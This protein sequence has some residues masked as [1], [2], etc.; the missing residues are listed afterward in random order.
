MKLRLGLSTK[1]ATGV[2]ITWAVFVYYDGRIVEFDRAPFLVFLTLGTLILGWG[3]RK[4]K[5]ALNPIS[6]YSVF[7]YSLAFQFLQVSYLQH[8]LGW[9]TILILSLAII[10]FLVP[11]LMRSKAKPLVNLVSRECN[12]GVYR[13][14]FYSAVVT[15]IIEAFYNQSLP[16]LNEIQGRS[17][18]GYFVY[19]PFAHYFVLMAAVLPAIAVY[20]YKA[21]QIGLG[22]SIWQGGISLFVVLNS[23]SRQQL[24]LLF[25]TV[26][27]VYESFFVTRQKANQIAITMIILFSVT[28]VVLGNLRT[29]SSDPTRYLVTFAQIKKTAEM[30]IV[31]VWF[32]KYGPENFS[33]LDTLIESLSR[34]GLQLGKYVLRPVVSVLFLDRIG[35]VTYDTNLDGFSKLGTYVWELYVDFGLPGLVLLSFLLGFIVKRTYER[36]IIEPTIGNSVA[37]A[38]LLFCVFMSAFTNYYFTFFIWFVLASSL[39]LQRRRTVHA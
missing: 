28:F 27:I 16:F 2:L 39:V 37:S 5:R 22:S 7:V 9:E 1:V 17:S 21:R 13:F 24:L 3:L 12:V 11:F 26:L 31:E 4:Y 15:F 38:A 33:H 18:Y 6:L 14:L 20:L 25:L 10:F 32:N 29:G 35:V 23:E 36:N 19:I 8:S 34:S 30:N